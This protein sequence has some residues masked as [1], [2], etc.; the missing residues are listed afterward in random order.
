MKHG[1]INR[2]IKF[3]LKRGHTFDMSETFRINHGYATQGYYFGAY[4]DAE[5][6]KPL[7]Q[8]SGST[9]N[10]FITPGNGFA[11]I[12]FVDLQFNFNSPNAQSD[13]LLFSSA[14]IK[15]ILMLR[16]D[17]YEPDN[18]VFSISGLNTMRSNLFMVS[19]TISSA[20][21]MAISGVQMYGNYIHGL[22]LAKQQ[23]RY[24]WESHRVFLLLR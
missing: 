20:E 24:L 14:N 3:C 1:H 10:H 21:T 16:C 2:V 18:G 23:F 11:Y 5:D 8:Y 19:S 7:I 13:G 17:F 6:E 22:V 15:N 4:G 9:T 12:G